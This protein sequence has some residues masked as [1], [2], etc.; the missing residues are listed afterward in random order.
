MSLPNIKVVYLFFPS[1]QFEEFQF[2]DVFDF[3]PFAVFPVQGLGDEVFQGF[4]L[5]V[6]Q[7]QLGRL[8]PL[9]LGHLE[10]EPSI[11]RRKNENVVMA[12]VLFSRFHWPYLYFS[13]LLVFE[14]SS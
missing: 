11:E 2:E 10:R 1:H 8:L 7:L 5:Q 4:V 9:E 3:G 14:L 13:E 6:Q 12:I